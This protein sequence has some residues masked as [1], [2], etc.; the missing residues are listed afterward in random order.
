MAY[1]SD[2][3]MG[4]S[5]PTGE[6]IDEAAWDGLRSLVMSA[7]DDGSFGERFPEHCPDGKGIIGADDNKLWMSMHGDIPRLEE[8]PWLPS[9]AEVPETVYILDMVEFCW[10]HISH[11]W[12]WEPHNHF[13]HNHLEFVPG[14]GQSNFREDVNRILRRNGLGYVL[15]EKGRVERIGPELLRTELTSARFQSGDPELDGMLEAAR[16][17]F[18]DY[19]H[20]VRREAL[21]ELWDAWERLKTTGQG[22]NK[23]DQTSNLLDI[24]A[25]SSYP[26]FRE[27]LETDAVELTSIGNSH[28]IRHTEVSQEKVEKGEHIDYLFHRL[29]SMINLILKTQ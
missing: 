6:Q 21:L 28:Q 15:N 25:G 4:S 12:H 29:F 20:E 24:A 14:L 3:E 9:S 8:K 19:H 1:F 13:K 18:L 5:P 2:R 26:K 16:A 7:I 11:A 17:K 27:R 23:A 22:S 10:K